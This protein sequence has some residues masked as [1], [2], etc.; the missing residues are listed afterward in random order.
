MYSIGEGNTSRCGRKPQ[1]VYNTVE[2]LGRPIRNFLYYLID[3]LNSASINDH[4]GLPLRPVSSVSAFFYDNSRTP[5]Y[6]AA[7]VCRSLSHATGL[8]AVLPY[9]PARMPC[10]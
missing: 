5:S 6:S 10:S 2:G 8:S 4:C 9:P 1:M 3:I 7:L